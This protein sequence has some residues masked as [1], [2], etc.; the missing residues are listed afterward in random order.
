MAP[1]MLTAGATTRRWSPCSTRRARWPRQAATVQRPVRPGFATIKPAPVAPLRHRRVCPCPTHK[2]Q[3]FSRRAR[4][5][6][7]WIP[8]RR[9]TSGRT[10]R[11]ATCASPVSAAS[12][13][14]PGTRARVPPGNTACDA[15]SSISGRP[16]WSQVAPISAFPSIPATSC[17]MAVIRSNDAPPVRSRMSPA[18]PLACQP[19]S[20]AP[21]IAATSTT[22]AWLGSAA[23]TN[24]V[25]AFAPPSAA[26]QNPAARH[27]KA[28]VCTSRMT[29]PAWVSARRSENRAFAPPLRRLRARI[30]PDKQRQARTNKRANAV[31][32]ACRYF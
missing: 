29:Q 5:P 28:A 8:D 22:R 9:A 17:S 6:A 25:A 15:S 3:R 21:A 4:R 24:G 23:S 16:A 12:S 7:R 2:V 32:S 14:A 26:A 27:K 19:A 1:P 20:E 18:R 10:A 13:A 31:T 11:R 30:V